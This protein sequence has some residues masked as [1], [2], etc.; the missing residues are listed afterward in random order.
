[1]IHAGILLYYSDILYSILRMPKIKMPISM[2]TNNLNFFK[3]HVGI[4]FAIL[5]LFAFFPLL[6]VVL[7]IIFLLFNDKAQRN[8]YYFLFILLSIYLG[9]VNCTKLP[10]GDMVGYLEI[11]SRVPNYSFYDN[12]FMDK[13]LGMRE[14]GFSF[15]NYL[16]YYLILGDER[17]YIVIVTV[18]IYMFQFVALYLY[19]EKYGKNRSF[20]LMGVIILAFFPPYFNLSVHLIRQMLAV[21]IMMYILVLKTVKGTIN[22]LMLVVAVFVHTT[23]AIFVPILFLQPLQKRITLTSLWGV[24]AIILFIVFFGPYLS[25]IFESYLSFNSAL[26]YGFNRINNSDSLDDG[27]MLNVL[28]MYLLLAPLLLLSFFVLFFEKDEEYGPLVLHSFYIFVS[29]VLMTSS[30]PLVQYRYFSFLYSYIPYFFPVLLKSPFVSDKR[31]FAA[32]LVFFI[33]NFFNKI[34]S[35]VWRYAPIL[36]LMSDNVFQLFFNRLHY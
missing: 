1:V 15:F 14:P 29:L 34:E 11:F 32:I 20:V 26:S 21:S 10:D 28:V 13:N 5:I 4:G 24:L 19:W 30:V 2:H 12:V 18:I 25:K 7:I 33:I 27:S 3:D 22:W 9:L 17:W 16:L 8:T 31:V 36:D 35:S 6:V 23:V